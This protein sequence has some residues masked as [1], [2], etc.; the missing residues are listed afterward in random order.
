MI[1]LTI[2]KHIN[3]DKEIR[4]GGNQIHV[5]FN[6]FL[7]LPHSHTHTHN[8]VLAKLKICLISEAG[9]DFQELGSN[10]AAPTYIC[11]GSGSLGHINRVLG[12]FNM[13]DLKTAQMFVL[14]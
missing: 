11:L 1:I 10:P 13:A 5:N 14:I 7:S 2:K 9:Q 3:I 4:G 12:L 8:S 6:H